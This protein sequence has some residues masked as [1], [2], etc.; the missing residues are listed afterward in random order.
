MT[1]ESLR[2][3]S[4][5][6]L[7]TLLLTLYS[8]TTSFAD[9]YFAVLQFT[10]PSS[11]L[12]QIVFQ[13][14]NTIG[15]CKKLNENHWKGVRTSCPKC[16]KDIASC[17]KSIPPSYKGIYENKPIIFP[18]LSSKRDRIVF[19]GV[20]MDDAIKFCK[21]LANGYRT[22]LNRPATAIMPMNIFE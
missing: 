16:V 1:M 18:Y 14:C 2:L 4:Y 5:I 22:K 12:T 9:D 10:D 11:G 8:S 19:C 7:M 21:W 15:L 17:L 3:I 6:F 13:Q 20:A